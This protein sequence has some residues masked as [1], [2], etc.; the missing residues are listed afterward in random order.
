MK[1][2]IDFDDSLF[3]TKKFREKLVDIFL[4]NGVSRKDFF[5]TY[6]DY[7]QKTSHGL[8]KYDPIRQI[9]M[10]NETLALNK[11]KLGKDLKEFIKDT[12][13]YVF[14][15]VASFLEICRRKDLYLISFGYTDFQFKKI[16]NSGLRVAF[17]K[18]MITDNNKNITIKSFVH[19]EEKFVFIDDRIENINLIKK[20]FPA[21]T[22]F[23]LKRK[24]GRYND[25]KTE[26]VDFEIKN[27]IEAKKII[28]QIIG[29]QKT[30]R[31]KIAHSF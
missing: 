7:P 20:S 21:S 17:R 14:S 30:H 1:I 12:K 4:A 29:K 31:E 9:K 13:K 28:K 24:E 18:M 11:K 6:Y 2:F 23:L 8:K 5:A 3:N 25:K 26:A 10:L 15:D 22:T 19:K 27:L 16:K